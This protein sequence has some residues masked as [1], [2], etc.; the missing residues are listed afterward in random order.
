MKRLYL[1]QILKYMTALQQI[2]ESA[3]SNREL[4]KEA[5][6]QNAIRKVIDFLD[7]V[8]MNMMY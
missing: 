5:E 4:L 6:T 1:W 8:I 7:E 3:W 2:I